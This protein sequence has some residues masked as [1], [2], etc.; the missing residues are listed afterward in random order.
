MT[1]ELKH[2]YC[3]YVQSLPIDNLHKQ[4]HDFRYG[5]RITNDNELFGRLLL[6]IN[7]AGLSWDI[8]LKK[9]DNF[10]KAFDN[11]EINKIAGYTNHKVEELLNNKGIIRN[12]LKVNAAVYNAQR[13]IEL[14]NEHGSFYQWLCIH[15][16]Q[17]YTKEKWTKL[18]KSNFKFTGGEIVGEFL[19]STGFLAGAHDEN[20]AIHS[21]IKNTKHG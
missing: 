16:Q 20:C 18:F 3:K 11:F 6:E 13:I 5:Y 19:M 8:I 21:L 2:P 7:Q 17:D 1:K 9:E 10:R 14:Q 15:E 12:K 4:Y